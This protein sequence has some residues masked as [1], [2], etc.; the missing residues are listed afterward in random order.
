MQRRIDTITARTVPSTYVSAFAKP[1]E[2]P[3]R[4]VVGLMIPGFGELWSRVDPTIPE[5]AYS[6]DEATSEDMAL[7]HDAGQKLG[8]FF[9]RFFVEPPRVRG[10][11]SDPEDMRTEYT[12]CH[13]FG[14]WMRGVLA[15][16]GFELPDEPNHIVEMGR[17]GRQ[18][19]AGV[20]GVLGL[21]DD[22]AGYGTAMHSVVG[23]GED[24]D[25]CMQVL[26]SQGFMGIDTYTNVVDYYQSL[27]STGE[28]QVKI[29]C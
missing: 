4:R 6:P 13:R 29:Y 2:I 16:E 7:P 5:S 20:H 12:N 24:S 10:V 3:Y 27:P 25:R 17:V 11:G 9:F 28:R 14:Y 26:A 23:L 1:T 15:A 21:R 19:R 22:A 8:R 18:L